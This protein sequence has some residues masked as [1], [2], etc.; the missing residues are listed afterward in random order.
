MNVSP[1]LCLLAL[2]CAAIL[3]ILRWHKQYHEQG[4]SIRINPWYG[5]YLL[6][7]IVTAAPMMVAFKSTS[8]MLWL[9][10][11]VCSSEAIDSLLAR[12][13][14]CDLGHYSRVLNMFRALLHVNYHG[15]G[16]GHKP[17]HGKAKPRHVN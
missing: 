6:V 16:R 7:L 8:V 11:M 1:F 10:D 3:C 9:A 2:N 4:S 17:T 13:L 12:V 14:D 15:T 5:T